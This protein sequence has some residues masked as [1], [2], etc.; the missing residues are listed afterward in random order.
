MISIS[1]LSRHYDSLT[2]VDDVSFEIN[3]GEIVGLLGHNGAG[4]ST[5][6]KMLSGYL[7][8]SQGSITI[9]GLPIEKNRKAVQQMI[10]YLP[11]NLPIYPELKVIDYLHYIGSIRNLGKDLFEQINLVIAA[12]N[13]NTKIYQPIDTLSR[14]YKQRV[15]VAGAIISNPKVLIL[16]EPTNGL[17]PTQTQLMRQ[18]IKDLA[19]DT[20][21]ILSTHIM[22][23]VEA[24]CNR[25]LIMNNG[26]LALDTKLADL[27]NNH[28]LI[29]KTKATEQKLKTLI[30]NISKYALI[31]PI[32]KSTSDYSQYTIELEKSLDKS[33]LNKA[34]A[35]IVRSLIMADL[36]VLSIYPHKQ[37][38]EAIFREINNT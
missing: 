29:L 3:R 38:L 37:S 19:K 12:T 35:E 5:V 25:V 21:V 30:A 18:L 33:A 27:H 8:P 10:G 28:T 1:N 36:E 2:A 4:K 23:E 22:Q 15:A 16:D 13:L 34:S 14:G 24:T 32:E 11:E 31:K 9:N 7:E 26:K 6:M 20:T 17:D